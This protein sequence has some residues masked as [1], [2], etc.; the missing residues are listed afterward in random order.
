[1]KV[2]KERYLTY[3]QVKRLKTIKEMEKE[4]ENRRTRGHEV[5]KN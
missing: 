3:K 2:R 4:G 1:V 5:V